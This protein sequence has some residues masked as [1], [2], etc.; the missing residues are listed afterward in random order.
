MQTCPPS[1]CINNFRKDERHSN[2]AKILAKPGC[3]HALATGDYSR[4]LTVLVQ[5]TLSSE[6]VQR[7]YTK[8]HVLEGLISFLTITGK[9]SVTI[10]TSSL[11]FWFT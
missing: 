1:D 3:T 2:H 10:G 11:L 6:R 8:Q 7:V 5:T 9:F 4:S